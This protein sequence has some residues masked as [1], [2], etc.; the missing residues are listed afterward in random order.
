MELLL[1]KQIK[2]LFE[3]QKKR[4]ILLGEISSKTDRFPA[5]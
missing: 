2:A 4:F 1:E 3:A 5:H